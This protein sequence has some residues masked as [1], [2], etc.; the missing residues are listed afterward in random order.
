MGERTNGFKFQLYRQFTFQTNDRIVSSFF[1]D[2][3]MEEINITGLVQVKEKNGT[4]FMKVVVGTPVV[5]TTNDL[6]T[7]R[8]VLRSLG[9]KFLEY[10]II[11]VYG[12]PP[13]TPGIV[14]ILYSALWCKVKV[15]AIYIGEDTLL[16]IDVRDTEK[17]LCILNQIVV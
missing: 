5:Q 1:N 14:N 3:A 16:Y 8:C 4:N 9:V 11:Q 6:E 2:L 12:F 15:R 10:D 7:T 17:A 13:E